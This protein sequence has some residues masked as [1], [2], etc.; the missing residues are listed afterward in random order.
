[1]TDEFENRCKTC[2]RIEYFCK[3]LTNGICPYCTPNPDRELAIR[4]M[5]TYDDPQV[6]YTED[7]YKRALRY[8]W[9]TLNPSLLPTKH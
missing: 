4:I 3:P 9:T 1:M 2:N 5:E 6:S 7:E 8:A